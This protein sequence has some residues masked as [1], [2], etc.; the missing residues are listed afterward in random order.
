M[1]PFSMFS[2]SPI[3]PSNRSPLL[4]ALCAS[5]FSF[6]PPR[7][8]PAC[9]ERSRRERSE[10][11]PFRF[12]PLRVLSVSAFSSPDVSSFN[13]KLS[14]F[15]SSSLTPFPVTLTSHPQLNE[16]SAILSPVPATLTR[17]VKHNPF[18]C[19]SYEKHPGWGYIHQAQIFFFRNL[20]THYSLLSTNSFTIRTS[21]KRACNPCRMRSFKT[22]DLKPFRMCSYE[23][24][25][26]GATHLNHS[27]PRRLRVLCVSALSFSFSFGGFTLSC[28]LLTSCPICSA[29]PMR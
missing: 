17:R 23:K 21:P 5:A 27:S 26:R 18:V 7:C 9:P 29:H 4:S 28:R 8:H 16:N 15:N 6:L 19:H 2:S 3:L 24:T 14:T 11:S 13:S 10:G 1:L 25:G 22:Q 12:S 20:T